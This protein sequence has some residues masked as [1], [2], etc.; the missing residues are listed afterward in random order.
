MPATA[1]QHRT[2]KQLLQLALGKARR[3]WVETV[4]QARRYGI[5]RIETM[6]YPKFVLENPPVSR[7]GSTSDENTEPAKSRGGGDKGRRGE[8]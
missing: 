5:R 2:P 8:G 1:W 3:D 7:L 4:L 6:S